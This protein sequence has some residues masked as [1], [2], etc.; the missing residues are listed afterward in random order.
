MNLEPIIQRSKSEK[1]NKYHILTHMYVYMGSREMVLMNVF[2]GQ[3]WRCR[4]T[5]QTCGPSGGR[6][7]L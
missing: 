4:Y 6:M 7:Q 3:K 1:E 2:V 5:E